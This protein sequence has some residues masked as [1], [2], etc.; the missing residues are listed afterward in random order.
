MGPDQ[1]VKG[2]QKGED[3]FFDFFYIV[4]VFL[5]YYESLLISGPLEYRALGPGPGGPCGPCVNLGLYIPNTA[6]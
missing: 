2:G 1:P 3:F 5:N 6:H 4:K